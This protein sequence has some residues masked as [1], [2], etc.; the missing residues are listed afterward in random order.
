[1]SA[2]CKLVRVASGGGG[3]TWMEIGDHPN[4]SL[5]EEVLMGLYFDPL[6]LLSN[7]LGLLSRLDFFIY[8]FTVFS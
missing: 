6:L 1:M 7:M 2:K 3:G 5:L 8:P 4:F